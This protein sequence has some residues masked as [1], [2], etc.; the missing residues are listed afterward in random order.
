MKQLSGLRL[1]VIAVVCGLLAAGLT[2]FYMQQVESKYRKAAQPKKEVKVAVIVPRANMAKGARILK[3]HIASRNVPEKYLPANAILSKDFKKVVN[4][5]LLSPIQKGRPITWEALTG[6]AARTFSEVVDQGRRALTVKISKVDSFDGLLRPGDVIDLM[7]VFELKE[8]GIQSTGESGVSDE[9]VMPVLERVRVLEASRQDLQSTRYELK[10]DRNSADGFNME[11]SMITLDLTP[12]QVARVQM[13][14]NTGETFAVLRH[15]KDTSMADYE[16]LGVEMLLTKDDP[17]PVDLVLDDNGQPIGRV[18]GDN[19]VDAQGKIVGK[20]VDG[21]AVSF[22]GQPLG[23]IVT[24]VSA[25]DAI[26]RVAKIADVVRD[27]DGK[28]IGH[29]ENGKIVDAAGNEIGRVDADGNAVGLQGEALGKV[30]RG[31]ALDINGN[32]VDTSSSS[33][34][35]AQTRR[36]QVVRD[37]N[38]Q[39]IGKV[40]NGQVVA[41]DGRVIGSVDS[42]GRAIG[43][44]GQ[45]L[46]EVEQILVNRN[47][48]VLGRE[49][50]VVRDA[51][52]KVLGRVEGNTIVD[53][54]GRVIGTLDS[55]GR[56]VGLDG[57]NLGEVEKVLIGRDGEVLESEST[58]VRDANG[59]ILGRVVN[60]KVV[61]S[62]GTVVGKV[63]SDGVARDLSGNT[64]GT[65]DTVMLDKNGAVS[66]SVTDVIRDK[67]GNIIGQLVDGK[68]VDSRGNVVGDYRN[69]QVIDGSGRVIASGASVTSEPKTTVVAEMREQ[70][71]R[72]IT[73]KI[74]MVDFIAGGTSKDGITPVT[75]VR[76]GQ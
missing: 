53:A 59:K 22:D 13:A 68:V 20:V 11:F 48:E 31:V 58:V 40:I 24:N 30:E 21:K 62:N 66:A 5:T 29:I 28:I 46:G 39:V 67:D 70:Q 55:R 36:E 8:L 2:I 10:S 76:V 35:A 51:T 52:G 34:A 41:A 12:K 44:D 45:S 4:R 56:A 54:D 26:N 27:A 19:I 9:V 72:S 16:Y 33:V 49:A 17:E 64:L 60:G 42:S 69:G 75:K 6:N 71:S 50:K 7:G 61:D 74:R 38:G 18:I 14:Q 37:V 1:F 43:A 57:Q 32:E 3:K 15:P 65:L 63:G 47:G 73:R 23:Q 25:D